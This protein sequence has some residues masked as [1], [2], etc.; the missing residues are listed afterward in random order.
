MRLHQHVLICSS[1]QA[2]IHC[3]A[4]VLFVDALTELRPSLWSYVPKLAHLFDVLS[5]PGKLRKCQFK[6]ELVPDDEIRNA[7]PD[8]KL[9]ID[10]FEFLN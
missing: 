1:F 3:D 9:L 2:E 6:I 10:A 5:N 4:R 7:T 8:S